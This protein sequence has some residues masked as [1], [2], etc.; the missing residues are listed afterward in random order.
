MW[1]RLAP[2]TELNRGSGKAYPR[3]IASIG[4]FASPAEAGRGLQQYLARWP[5]SWYQ[6]ESFRLVRSEG[7]SLSSPP[8]TF[9]MA[10]AADGTLGPS[11]M[12]VTR[13]ARAA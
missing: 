7:A 6:A 5:G 8:Q 13:R 2:I 9:V 1:S 12:P 10:P 3:V 11:P 4:P